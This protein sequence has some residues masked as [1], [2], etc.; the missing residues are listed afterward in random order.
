MKRKPEEAAGEIVSASL[1][2]ARR[3][4]RSASL[5]ALLISLVASGALAQSGNAELP[6][7]KAGTTAKS[8]VNPGIAECGDCGG[9]GGGTPASVLAYF[10]Q[11]VLIRS[12]E[13]VAALGPTLMGDS[14]NEFSGALQFTHSD[15]SLPGNNALPVAVG[16]HLAAGGRQAALANGLFGDWDLDIP[17]F[18]TVVAQS[19]GTWY[20][21]GTGAPNLLRCSQFQVP[22]S[23]PVYQAADR[24]TVNLPPA[25]WWDGYSM[26][27]P[28]AGEQTLLGRV[29][30]GNLVGYPVNPSQPTDGAQYPILTKQHWQISC[31]PSLENGAGE[32]FVAHAPNGTRYQ[33]DHMVARSYPSFK[34]SRRGVLA[35]NEV[36]VLPTQVTDRFGNWVRYSY[37]GG[38]GWR[39]ASISSSDGRTISF[40][41]S[42]NDNRID[43][44]S[45][46]TRTWRYIY[47]AA[48]GLQT[49]T[50]PDASQWQFAL[51]DLERDPY[52]SADKDCLIDGEPPEMPWDHTR[53]GT[54]VHPSGAVGTFEVAMRMHGRSNIPGTEAG[55]VGQFYAGSSLSYVNPVSRY[56]TNYA[57]LY[58]TLAGPG[59]PAMRWTYD[60]GPAK[61]SFAPCN[62]CVNTKT[63]TTTDPSGNVVQNTY[64]TQFGINDGLLL[65]STEGS[66]GN[67]LRSTSYVY[68]GSNAG[69]FPPY[70]GYLAGA[71]DS[72]SNIHTPQS[73][74]AILQ[75]GVYF[76][77]AATGFDAYA[78]TT[79]VNGTSSLGSR[80]QSTV[81][82]DN[83]NL[84]VLGQAASHTIAGVQTSSTSYDPNTA[85]PTA[86]YKFGKLQATY[87][88]NA[89]GTLAR[90]VD[91]LNHVTTFSSYM[92][93]LPQRIGYADGTSISG[94]VQ[95][96]GV[97]TSVT[98]EA[99]TTWNYGYD[100]MGR[101]SSKTPPSGDGVAYNPTYFLFEQVPYAE[102][103][104]E[105]N[106]WRQ[107][108]ATGNAFTV[109]YF[110]ARWRKRLTST[111]DASNPGATQRMQRFDY[112]PYNRTTYASYPARTIASIAQAAPGTATFYD[113]L[114][115]P[116]LTVADSELGPLT[117]TTQY[118]GGFQK[119][120]T[121]PRGFSTVT[122]YQAFGEPSEAAITAITAPEGVSVAISRDVFGK[123]LAVTRGGA[124][125]GSG[126]ASVTRSYVYDANQLLCK[127]VEPEI[128][129]TIQVLDAANNVSWRA[130]GVGLTSTSSCD[131][132]SVPASKIIGHTYDAR[133]RLTGTG[134]GDGSPAIGRAYTPDGL[135]ASVVSY[136]STLSYI[137]NNRRLLTA[138]K[139]NYGWDWN[140]TRT[141]D[142]NAHET[143][144]TYPDGG[145]QAY[146]RNALGEVTQVVGHANGVT[147]HPN[148][149]VASYTLANG[150]THTATQNTRGLPRL[151]ID[152]GV[153]QDQY[154]YDAN[155]NIAGIADQQEGVTTRSMGYDALDRLTAVN[156]PGL[157]G[158]AGYSYDGLD[159]LRTS[160]IGGRNSVHNY[161]ANNRLGSI[162]TN[163]AFTAYAYDGQGNITARGTQGFY[164][165]QGNRMVLANNKANYAY[166]GL[167][168][169]LVTDGVNGI[170]VVQYYSQS[171]QQLFSQHRQGGAAQNIRHI[172]LGGKQIAEVNSTYGTS[173]FHTDALG[174]PVA[175]TNA[176]GALVSR[177]RYE[178][179]GN[180]AAG[181]VPNGIGFTG[182][183]N[184]PDTGLVYM[185]Q[186]YYDPVAGRFMSV[187]PI[188]TDANTGAMFNV[189]EYANN[190]PYRHTDPDGRCPVCL[191][192]IP[193]IIE[194]IVAAVASNTGAVVV[195]IA[196]GVV[197][198]AASQS[199]GGNSAG[200]A[201]GA[202]A[203]SAS[204]SGQRPSKTPNTGPPGSTYVN[205]GSGQER[206][207]GPDGRPVRDIDHDH[208]HDG[209]QPHQHDWVDGKRQ[210]GVAVPPPTTGSTAPA[211]P[212]PGAGTAAP[213]AGPTPPAPAQRKNLFDGPKTFG[214]LS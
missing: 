108:I 206:T 179:Y 76:T 151:N 88:F 144:L 195:G 190:N 127:T 75:Q 87:G 132:A 67:V 112:D 98:N 52:S 128:G 166:D 138:E 196:G 161:D 104:L 194:A 91:G 66:S 125:Y 42:A 141:Y 23:P 126:P 212:A 100:T 32:G 165:D 31:L 26:H 173:Y 178:P 53:I 16:R 85:L 8:G 15:V 199:N 183:V 74:R 162:N 160:N 7:P 51:R 174:S 21:N 93:G 24:Q 171:G 134:F 185:Q 119:Q 137:Y 175:K 72:M 89:D 123:P 36:W 163:G 61:G 41:Y 201:P 168:R 10:E 167:G 153:M 114:G 159:N 78:R 82:A 3:Y 102:Y 111:Y 200:P 37:G 147:Y 207:Y 44:V 5:L 55:C 59:M 50:L 116:T 96:I 68:Q 19:Q 97:L 155:G 115:R 214:R 18:R 205:P 193:A 35:R 86:S 189:Y 83:T 186:R 143:R 197:I 49:V 120:V 188:V 9:G 65:S 208:P 54:I 140:F 79:G 38:D 46:G 156:A 181:T 184:D 14:V 11:N 158:S 170:T 211:A 110:D 62:G 182:H 70:V 58:K 64:G 20:G 43:S 47:N 4:G 2:T 129:A 48:G 22:P 90:I 157:W 99:G 113:A 60:Y 27:I 148:G 6:N 210:P 29:P 73:Q 136:P 213:G 191:P 34:T 101:I 30:T 152:A 150:I 145:A 202:A 25:Y 39:V 56:F 204:G 80:T 124:F 149:A 77:Q 12:G 69:P 203:E 106:H 13:I 192:A 109:N 146:V 169:R 28:G 33:F 121:N 95:N 139:F 84:W 133:N 164:F 45:D 142:A 1:C 177:T 172:Y 40:G 198:G 209:I 187:D 103:G 81:Y 107:T 180:T 57:L 92:R 176:S 117:T 118:L 131:S 122:A 154:D 17:H 63:V 105:A 71:T 135:L 130:V 94:V